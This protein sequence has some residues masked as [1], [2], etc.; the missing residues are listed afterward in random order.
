MPYL[1]A[2]LNSIMRCKYRLATYHLLRII[3]R[4]H[5]KHRV[6]LTKASKCRVRPCFS[7]SLPQ[8][9]SN[10]RITGCLG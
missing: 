10:L 6:L 9:L 2:Y 3:T 7:I 4:N 8:G 5:A 1:H